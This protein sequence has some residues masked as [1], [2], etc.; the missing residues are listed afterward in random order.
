MKE[1]IN[2]GQMMI[3]KTST[4]LA[5]RAPTKYKIE[6]RGFTEASVDMKLIPF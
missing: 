2:F 6:S 3:Q 1:I 4:H 5:T